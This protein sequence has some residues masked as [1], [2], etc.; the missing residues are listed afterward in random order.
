MADSQVQQPTMDLATLLGIKPATPQNI[1]IPFRPSETAPVDPTT[2]KKRTDPVAVN[3]EQLIVGLA[4]NQ[5][6]QEAAVQET[7]KL[8]DAQVRSMSQAQSVVSDLMNSRAKNFNL[9]TMLNIQTQELDTKL[10]AETTAHNYQADAY[11]SNIVTS[12]N[13]QSVRRQAEIDKTE[14]SLIQDHELVLA[15]ANLGLQDLAH[16]VKALKVILSAGDAEERIAANRQY[17]N[18]LNILENND[19]QLYQNKVNENIVVKQ[20]KD[21]HNLDQLKLQDANLKAQEHMKADNMNLD[22]MA[23]SLNTYF[24]FSAQELSAIRIKIETAKLESDTAVGT[25]TAS[26]QLAGL[27]LQQQAA[28]QAL[29]QADKTNPLALQDAEKRLTYLDGQIK[30]ISNNNALAT[31]QAILLQLTTE[32]QQAQNDKFNFEFKNQKT[33]QAQ[34]ESNL[35]LLGDTLGM[36][37]LTPT[38]FDY[39]NRQGMFKDKIP[40]LSAILLSGGATMPFIARSDKPATLS[41]ET[42]AKHPEALTTDYK[43]LLFDLANKPILSGGAKLNGD[44]AYQAARQKGDVA[45][46]EALSNKALSGFFINIDSN[47]DAAYEIGFGRLISPNQMD[48]QSLDIPAKSL[49]LMKE[50]KL[51]TNNLKDF[52]NTAIAR[53][54]E[55]DH[56]D[57]I[58]F[59]KGI[60]AVA[61][62]NFDNFKNATGIPMEH[63]SSSAFRTISGQPMDLT[64]PM[65]TY[66]LL[67]T[68]KVSNDSVNSES[69]KSGAFTNF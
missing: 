12:N 15:R 33:D 57:L 14:E 55:L 66:E 27:Q 47:V 8:S 10:G 36:K 42:L 54:A 13:R 51:P 60:A 45:E 64:N 4:K 41:A 37:G 67:L 1:T 21:F 2:G 31:N 29:D 68:R 28:Q 40:V 22:G 59:S 16:P 52:M 5:V 26:A 49:E 39:L 35:T 63:Y 24:Q 38:T 58:A 46:M 7:Q 17:I 50:L 43:A 69:Y 20:L 19:N 48:L 56:A 44:I 9:A 30:Q 61:Q 65:A 25:A 34:L 32:M 53:G 6:R 23:A 3:Y 62:R 11:L 18:D